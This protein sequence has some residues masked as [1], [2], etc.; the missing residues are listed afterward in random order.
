MFHRQPDNRLMSWE[1]Y[2]LLS[3]SGL[4]LRPLSYDK[5]AVKMK[6]FCGEICYY[7]CEVNALFQV[8]ISIHPPCKIVILVYI[9][10]Y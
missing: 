7:S 6:S 10:K 4:S 9:L 2:E 8:L 1:G 3:F 5:A